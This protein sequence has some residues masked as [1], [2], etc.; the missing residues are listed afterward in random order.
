MCS[1]CAFDL[2]IALLRCK[3]TVANNNY[4]IPIFQK[5]IAES[6]QH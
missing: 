1:H 5:K 6:A 2:F 3:T 4:L